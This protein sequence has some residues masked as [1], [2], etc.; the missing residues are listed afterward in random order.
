V[1]RPDRAPRPWYF[2]LAVWIIAL[3]LAIA[4]MLAIVNHGS[5]AATS[6]VFSTTAVAVPTG[7]PAATLHKVATYDGKATL[8]GGVIVVDTSTGA[9]GVD[10]VTGKKVWSY[11]RTD[12]PV[13]AR[14]YNNTRVFLVYGADGL[15]D[16][17]I[18][19]EASSG[20]RAWQRTIEADA[21]N[22]IAFGTDSMIS[23]T[24]TQIIAYEQLTGFALF[25][26]DADTGSTSTSGAGGSTSSGD[27]VFAAASAGPIVNVLQKCRASASDPWVY[28]LLAEDSQD[29]KAREVGH[30]VLKLANPQL[31]ASFL[32]GAGLVTD[33]TALYIAGGGR[34]DTMAVTG[35]SVTD[36]SQLRVLSGGGF[37]LITT[38]IAVYRVP[39]GTSAP[40][41]QVPT[42]AY[43]TMHG[44]EVATISDDVVRIYA[45]ENGTLTTQSTFADP[46][47]VGSGTT[48]AAV[49][50]LVAVSDGSHTTVYR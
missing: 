16:E 10:A 20:A 42:S 50:N 18:A 11:E 44:A 17:A 41:W 14:G 5:V 15:C 47:A 23:V 40:E 49:G 24:T 45:A 32:N 26:L 6:H 36:A 30:A 22:S 29:G 46:V 13:C 43:P 4:G 37:D 9:K 19:L 38:G 27:C 25:T 21:Q 8:I 33:G 39:P 35:I 2:R 31:V 12:L 28:A 7:E 3:G 34:T 1:A 48:V